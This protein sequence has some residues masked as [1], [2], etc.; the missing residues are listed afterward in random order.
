M[1]QQLFALSL[2][3][4]GL[5]FAAHQAF[6][7]AAPQCADRSA[8][9]AELAARYGETRRGIG[10]AAGNA[11]MEIFASDDTGTWTITMTTAGGLTCLVASGENYDHLAEDLPASGKGA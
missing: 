10:L 3:F 4:G 1:K 8:V 5:V 9:V 11:V 6:G 2:G 7:Q